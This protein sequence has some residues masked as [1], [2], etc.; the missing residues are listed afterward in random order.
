MAGID[1]LEHAQGL[2]QGVAGAHLVGHRTDAA[3][4]GGD[5]GDF[6]EVAAAQE[7]LEEPRRL[8]DLQPHRFH[9]RRRASARAA[10]PRPRP[11]PA[12][13][14]ESFA[15]DRDH[16]LFE[17]LIMIARLL[18]GFQV[19]VEGTQHSFHFPRRQLPALG[20]PIA[21][22][23]DVRLLHGTEATVAGAVAAGTERAAAGLRDRS[24]AGL[25][26]A[27]RARRE[28]L[29]ACTRCTRCAWECSA[30]GPPA[31]PTISSNN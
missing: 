6:L 8:V 23:A 28:A 16:L 19:S 14:R 2:F 27:T 5:V 1:L 7:G 29:V 4:A 17:S 18:E 12:P 30:C 20:E 13:R 21:Q 10:R 24:Q 15:P 3:D 26:P 31:G 25:A 11:G 9:A 22:R